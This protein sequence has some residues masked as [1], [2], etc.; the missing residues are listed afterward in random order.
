[1]L[2][3]LDHLAGWSMARLAPRHKLYAD[4]WGLPPEELE[5]HFDRVVDPSILDHLP[6]LVLHW[7]AWHRPASGVMAREGLYQSPLPGLPPGLSAGRVLEVR[8]IGSLQ[9]TVDKRCL[10]L[11]AW[12]DEGWSK[13]LK[14]ARRLAREG[15]C[16]LIHETPYHGSRRLYADGSPI[17]RVDEHAT[18]IRMAVVEGVALV[19]ALDALTESWVVAGFS[20]G[21]PH[22]GA[23]ISFSGRPLPGALF[24]VAHSP[25]I[26]FVDG[27]LNRY[28]CWPALGGRPRAEPRLRDLLSRITLLT[29][30]RPAAPSK[31]L[32]MG[33]ERDAFVPSWAVRELAAHW[34]GAQVDWRGGGHGSLWLFGR[35]YMASSITERFD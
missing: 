16:S 24:A 2:G 6:P 13:R 25:S 33:A 11:G 7:Q 31:V 27:I 5:A 12:S 14:L 4:G 17:R 34:P 22:A 1:M 28:V 26:P 20:M 32:L 23:V 30:P 9:E 10:L 15:V 18:L 19:R 3:F 21:A 35:G 8:P 29:L